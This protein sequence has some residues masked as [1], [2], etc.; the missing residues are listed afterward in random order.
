MRSVLGHASAPTQSTDVPVKLEFD[1]PSGSHA[2]R[3]PV[4]SSNGG[5]LTPA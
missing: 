3:T 5:E 2:V 1:N 4:A